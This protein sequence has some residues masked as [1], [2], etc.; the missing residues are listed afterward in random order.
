VKF[1]KLNENNYNGSVKGLNVRV[2]VGDLFNA[3]VKAD[4]V[5]VNLT[6]WSYLDMF[7]AL[8]ITAVL[9]GNVEVSLRFAVLPLPGLELAVY[10]YKGDQFIISLCCIKPIDVTITEPSNG[11]RVSG[12]VKIQA[13]VKAVPALTVNNVHAWI[14]GYERPVPMEYNKASGLWE[15]VF[16]SYNTGNGWRGLNVR[17]DGVEWKG[18]QEFRYYDQDRI[19]VEIDNPWVNS[20]VRRD[21]GLEGFGGL[22]VDLVYDSASWMMGTGFNFW[23]REGLSVTAP[24][25][26]WDG[27]IRFNCWR[28]DDENGNPLLQSFH[29]TLNITPEIVGMLFDGGG[30]ARELKCI[31]EQ[32]PPP[33]P[34]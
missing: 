19:N 15:G 18:G 8:N 28:I 11:E 34:P 25:Y 17:A 16:Q 29:P 2:D 20:Y 33:P 13:S 31:Y 32:V 10:Q 21:W 12:D 30:R 24:E 22:K 6:Y 27:N 26:W 3:Y 5:D 9:T 14:D 7:P 23:P 4:K 1:Q